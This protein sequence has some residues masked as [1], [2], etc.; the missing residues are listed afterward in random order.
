MN[1]TN[2]N[3][4]WALTYSSIAFSLLTL[5][6]SWVV[7]T[8]SP[9]VLALL[10]NFSSELPVQTGFVANWYWVGSLIT[11]CLSV[12]CTIVIVTKSKS[13]SHSLLKKVYLLSIISVLIAFIWS[14]FVTSALYAPIFGMGSII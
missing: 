2:T 11:V 3:F 12:A 13:A 7:I 5:H 8:Q 14:G 10:N 9:K 1:Q 6:Q 4:S